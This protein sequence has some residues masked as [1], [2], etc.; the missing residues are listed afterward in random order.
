[1]ILLSRKTLNEQKAVM[2][3]AV[4]SLRRKLSR[5]MPLWTAASH[6][7]FCF[8]GKGQSKE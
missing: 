5:L 2:L 3:T 7:S 8:A 1:M 6:R 4:Q